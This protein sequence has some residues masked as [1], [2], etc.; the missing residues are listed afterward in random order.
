MAAGASP[1]ITRPCPVS[2]LV[3]L[4][5]AAFSGWQLVPVLQLKVFV[6]G[7]TAPACVGNMGPPVL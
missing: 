4:H 7:V 6:P 3:L 5:W 2:A 1:L